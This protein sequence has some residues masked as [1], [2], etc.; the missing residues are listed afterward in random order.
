MRRF[1]A[2]GDC[3]RLAALLLMLSGACAT[4]PIDRRMHAISDAD[5]DAKRAVAAEAQIDATKIPARSIGVL[6]FTVAG[7]DSVLKP[8]AYAMADFLT[9]DLSQSS[10]LQVVDRL[11][12][13]AIARELDLVDKGIADPR[14]APRVGRLVGARRLLI[15][16]VSRGPNGTVQ[17]TAR[18][19]DV[20]GST[21]QGLVSA[22]APIDR[23]I[24]AE[25]ALALRVL[26]EMGVTLTPTQRVAIER[27]E[28]T[29]LAATVAYG[30]G[31][32]AEAHGDAA[33]AVSAFQ[34]A[35]R[36]DAAF[37]AAR[38]QA[39]G[40]ASSATSTRVSSVQ[41]VLDLSAQAINAP[42]STKLPEAADVP[43]QT[44]QLLVLLISVRVF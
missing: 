6:P 38:A 32:E 16:D 19:V 12:L 39:S 2:A 33:R 22:S 11:H 10:Q 5:R 29:N 9:T 37:S 7:D 24:D 28:T 26:E 8:L 27:R 25:K 3:R 17:F 42:V 44:S 23:A 35:A 13:D 36:L 34:D 40:S 41:R 15:G 1:A 43:L 14:T 20:L 31:L 30:R 18:L 21:V 4:A